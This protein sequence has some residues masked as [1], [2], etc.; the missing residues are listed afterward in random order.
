MHL[1]EDRDRKN[2]SHNALISETASTYLRSSFSGGG[3]G[4]KSR[5]NVMREDKDKNKE[6]LRASLDAA[7]EREREYLGP[8]LQVSGAKM[9]VFSFILSFSIHICIDISI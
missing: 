6:N 5:I 7:T 9:P 1:L 4:L 2:S 3:I 8:Q